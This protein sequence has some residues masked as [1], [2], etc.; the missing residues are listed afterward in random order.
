[1]VWVVEEKVVYHLLNHASEQVRIPVRA[2]FEF[3]VKSGLFV[4]DTL[5][6]ETLYNKPFLRKRYPRLDVARL[7]MAIGETVHAAIVKHLE[8]AGLLG[9]TKG[10]ET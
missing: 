2:K 7:D 10:I 8:E 4:P 3:E 5:S 6:V 9:A 1:M